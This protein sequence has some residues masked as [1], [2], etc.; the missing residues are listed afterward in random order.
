MDYIISMVLYTS[1]GVKTSSFTS[2]CIPIKLYLKL[3]KGV[4]EI[5]HS[6]F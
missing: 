6:S 5:K 3:D 2:V 1:H 4:K